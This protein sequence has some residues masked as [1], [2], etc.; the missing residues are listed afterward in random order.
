MPI[1]EGD[2]LAFKLAIVRLGCRQYEVA[3]LVGVHEST[4]SA[5]LC[6]RVTLKG[7]QLARL[8]EVLRIEESLD[9]A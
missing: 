5:F 9:V 4:L 1:T 8:R 2:R 7:D 6:G 3:Q